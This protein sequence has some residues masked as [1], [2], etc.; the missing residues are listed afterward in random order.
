M[1][2]LIKISTV[3]IEYEFK[4]NDARTERR[5]GTAEIEISRA[6]GGMQIKSKPIKLDLDTFE[7]RNSMDPSTARAVAELPNKGRQSAY[8]ATAQFASEGK[9]LIRAQ[10]GEGS[11]AINR[12]LAGRTAPST[13]EFGLTFLPT[14]GPEI[15]WE[16][17]EIS[18]QYEMDKLQFDAKIDNGNIE[19]IPGS[20]EL[21][22]TQHPDVVI[23]YVGEP[24]FVPPSAA[25]YFGGDVMDI[26]A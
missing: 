6:K 1:E 21:S 5:S 13:G 10:I 4:I 20:I 11:E 26:E 2:Q 14:T 16:A 8:N 23:E 15:E 7:A 24:I 19:F 22:I 25:E 17:P 12:M 9:M 18:I 3:P